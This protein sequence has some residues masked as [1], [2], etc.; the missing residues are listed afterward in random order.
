MPLG[1]GL[2]RLC[3]VARRRVSSDCLHIVPL[4][5]AHPS[6]MGWRVV[7]QAD[8]VKHAVNHVKQ[9]FELG[10]PWLFLGNSGGGFPADENF[11]FE[12]LVGFGEIKAD[13]IGRVIVLE[14][15]TVDFLD[16]FVV[17]D[18]NRDLPG[19]PS[20]ILRDSIDSSL[21]LL[22]EERLDVG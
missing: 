21:D 16:T 10:G 17:Q 11:S 2:G 7:I 19:G 8:D 9:H 3:R 14:V 6:G 20:K 22:L 1:R 13:H 5:L 12:N 18:C 15:L 4:V